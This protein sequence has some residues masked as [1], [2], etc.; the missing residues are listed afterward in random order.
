ML[1]RSWIRAALALG[2]PKEDY[3]ATLFK[4]GMIAVRLGAAKTTSAERLALTIIAT[5]SDRCERSGDSYEG[6]TA[7]SSAP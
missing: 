1:F 4:L 2:V 7:L 3:D 5:I 6:T